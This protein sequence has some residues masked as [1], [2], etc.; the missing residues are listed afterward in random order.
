M[1]ATGTESESTKEFT[2]WGFAYVTATSFTSVLNPSAVQMVSEAKE[3]M[4]QGCKIFGFMSLLSML[5]SSGFE[6]RSSKPARLVR[7]MTTS[8]S[9]L[10]ERLPSLM[11]LDFKTW[12]TS[13][14]QMLGKLWTLVTWWTSTI[15][16]KCVW[17]WSCNDDLK[18]LAKIKN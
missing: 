14:P 16:K 3:G 17:Y 11:T 8:S 1:N 5:E 10:G 9:K 12:A 4:S 2:I 15:L 7:L 13:S 6:R 18:Y